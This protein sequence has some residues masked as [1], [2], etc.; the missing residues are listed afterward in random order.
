LGIE[1]YLAVPVFDSHGN[2]LGHIGIMHTGLIPNTA[3]AHTVLKI[4]ASK[5]AAQLELQHFTENQSISRPKR[6][7]T[8]AQIGPKGLFQ[9]GKKQ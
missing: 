3:L 7:I 1:S 6:K 8:A 4:F 2:P 5:T 9:K